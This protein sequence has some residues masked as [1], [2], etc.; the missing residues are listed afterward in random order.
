MFL[1]GLTGGIASGKTSVAKILKDEL[2][3]TVI[4]ADEVAREV[5]LPGTQGWKKI[6][7]NFGNDVFQPNGELNREKLGQI[8]FND[9][10][11]R[12]I[13]NSI[14]H[15]E[16]YKAI[17]WKVM[18]N[19]LL[20]QHFIVLD[21]PLL[22]ESKKMVP[23]MSYT[24]VVN[25]SEE[26]QLQRL[27]KRNNYSR[28]AAEIRIR[29]QMPLSEKCRLCTHI[30]DNTND[31]ESTYHQTVKFHKQLSQSL[32]YWKVR[33]LLAVCAGSVIGL[34]IYVVKLIFR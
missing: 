12:K 22:F 10:E 2:G 7:K 15:P 23:F 9:A 31:I 16:I 30:I 6:Q 26:Q 3:C 33:V 8:I 13:L 32:L 14:T 21:L 29:A 25:C 17:A 27:M 11:K 18:K 20:G 1:V 24:V 34:T 4:D 28:E 5:V 19:F